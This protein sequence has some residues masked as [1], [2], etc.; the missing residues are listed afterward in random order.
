MSNQPT[1]PSLG[2]AIAATLRQHLDKGRLGDARRSTHSADPTRRSRSSSM[3]QAPP[4]SQPSERGLR[5]APRPTLHEPSTG[6]RGQSPRLGAK[7]EPPAQRTRT[8][9]R[10]GPFSGR[11][12]GGSTPGARAN[13]HG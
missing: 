5:V 9:N 12:P 3:R 13:P 8:A 1:P 10:R 6:R 7:A 4:A 11:N 2:E